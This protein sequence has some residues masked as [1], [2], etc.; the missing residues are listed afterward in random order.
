LLGYAGIMP[1][2]AGHPL[3]LHFDIGW[4]LARAAWGKGYATEAARAALRDGF[5]RIGLKEV[6]AYTS[7][8]NLRS[9]AVIA[10]LNLHR[11]ATLDYCEPLGAGEWRGL[12]WKAQ[13]EQFA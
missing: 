12:V 1:S 3:G 9:Q 8:D 10:R 6:L 5:E 11:A 2:R 4:R 7:S 13:A